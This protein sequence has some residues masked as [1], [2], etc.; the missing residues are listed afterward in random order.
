[1]P[2]ADVV[3]DLV[4]NQAYGK[5]FPLALMDYHRAARQSASLKTVPLHQRYTNRGPF[6]MHHLIINDRIVNSDL[7]MANP[8]VIGANTITQNTDPVMKGGITSMSTLM[9]VILI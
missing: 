6:D 9:L 7:K 2:K 1:M 8:R 4:L 5:A 3:E